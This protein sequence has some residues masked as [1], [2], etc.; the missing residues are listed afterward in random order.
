MVIH[1]GYHKERW[2]EEDIDRVRSDNLRWFE[3]Y[4]DIARKHRVG[5][6]IENKIETYGGNLEQLLELVDAF[7]AE[8][9]KIC[10][11]T[12]H[13]HVAGYDQKEALMT[14]GGRLAGLHIHDN[15]GQEDA[16]LQPREGN[17]DWQSFMDGL[18]AID[19][20]GA[21]TFETSSGVRGVPKEMEDRGLERMYENGVWLNSLSR[22]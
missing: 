22:R 10:W 15:N 2:Q 8:D 20:R 4:V 17:I 14:I 7:G 1:A 18:D 21:L 9:V 5:I 11:D 19:Y 6:L 3:K 16:H 12:G 13:G